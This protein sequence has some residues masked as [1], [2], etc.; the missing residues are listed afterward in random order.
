MKLR[1]MLKDI[2]YTLSVSFIMWQQ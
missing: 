1:V 2:V